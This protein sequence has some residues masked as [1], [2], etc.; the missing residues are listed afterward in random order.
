MDAKDFVNIT[1][2]RIEELKANRP[3]EVLIIAQ[4][5]KTA[6]QLRVQRKGTDANETPF[7]PYSVDYK[8]K[9]KEKG[10]QTAFVD[11]T[12]KGALWNN[13]RPVVVSSNEVETV[14]EIG[15]TN[16]ENRLKLIGALR[17][18][19]TAPRGSG[20]PR[21]KILTPSKK[22]REFAAEAN[23]RRLLKY[24]TA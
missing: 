6:M 8:K 14:V 10:R 21:G 16:A 1:R 7:E 11:F 5:L 3:K 17:T 20:K 22:E 24:L 23:K 18:P 2:T 15:P 9:R 19:I 12:F 4:E 13:I